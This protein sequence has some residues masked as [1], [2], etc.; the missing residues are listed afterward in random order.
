[1]LYVR[2]LYLR[3]EGGKIPELKRVIVAYQNKIAMAETLNEAFR[4]VVAV[5]S[6]EVSDGEEEIEVEDTEPEASREELIK[7][8]Q[9]L[10]EQAQEAQQQGMWKEY[11]EYVE[12]LGKALE[13]LE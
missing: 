2:P 7:R 10:F 11:G 13:E 4:K 5:E 8:A 6:E 3:A 9:S 12:E 1:M